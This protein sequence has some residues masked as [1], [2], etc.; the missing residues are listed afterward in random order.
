MRA[1]SLVGA[2]IAEVIDVLTTVKIVAA[3]GLSSIP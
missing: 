1:A 2:L 3:G